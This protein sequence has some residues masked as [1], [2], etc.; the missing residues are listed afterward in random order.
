MRSPCPIRATDPDWTG[1]A[2][3]RPFVGQRRHRAQPGNRRAALHREPSASK[4]TGLYGLAPLNNVIAPQPYLS[5]RVNDSFEALR[6]G[7]IKEPV[8]T[9]SARS[10][11]P[12]GHRIAP[13]N[14]ASRAENWHYTGRA[15]SIDRN[16]IYA[17]FA[18]PVEIV[19]EDIEVNTYW[20]VY[21]R[22]VNEAQNGAL[23]EP[24]RRLPWDF[25][26]RSSGDV[27]D[28]E[29]G[30]RLK[31]SPPP[32]YYVDLTQLADDYG[33]ERLPPSAPGST[34]SARS[35][36]GSSSKLMG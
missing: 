26:A 15:I 11:M 2:L 33:W 3:P 35:S 22:V 32:G 18:A 5:D 10:K 17:G 20:R 9:F 16:L 28:Y 36:S 6:M 8:T 1:T 31:D 25:T 13:Q 7:V 27:E 4:A 34:T 14:P 24:L 21:V 29:R 12:S 23:G 19:R 30:G